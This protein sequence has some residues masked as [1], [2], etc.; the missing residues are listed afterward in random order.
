MAEKTRRAY[1][2]GDVIASPVLPLQP[3]LN[4]P[5]SLDLPPIIDYT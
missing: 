1:A 4:L 2:I 5:A 3:L